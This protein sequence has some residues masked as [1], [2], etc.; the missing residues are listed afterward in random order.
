MEHFDKFIKKH[1]EKELEVPAGLSW[2]EMNIP[3]PLEKN[4]SRNF[5]WLLFLSGVVV[6]VIVCLLINNPHHET[7]RIIAAK[8]T[9]EKS[10]ATLD[11]EI[12]QTERLL[13]VAD[14]GENHMISPKLRFNYS[15]KKANSTLQKNN[16]A[17]AIAVPDKKMQGTRVNIISR[18]GSEEKESYSRKSMTDKN[19]V[20]AAT[21]PITFREQIITLGHIGAISLM[22]KQNA[23]QPTLSFPSLEESLGSEKP[24]RR[25]ALYFLGGYTYS[26]NSY[27][28]G[29]QARTLSEV[30]SAGHGRVFRLGLKF[31]LRNRFFLNSEVAAQK[32][33]T[34]FMYSE[35]LGSRY[36]TMYSQ[37]VER[38]RH[39]CH[40][41]S[42]ET[43]G[44][45]LGMGRDF[46]LGERFGSQVTFSF[47][48]DHQISS[49]GRTLNEDFSVHV[50]DNHHTTGGIVS[51]IRADLGV[52]YNINN[53]YRLLGRVG[54]Q[55]SITMKK[56]LKN[57]DLK[58]SPRVF[59]ISIGIAKSL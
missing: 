58:Y 45:R 22:L 51:G 15:E 50:M 55:Q 23:H 1:T 25:T 36:S 28:N 17:A 7:E 30:E 10:V 40:N 27:S 14:S 6:G 18:H 5:I 21:L 38:I 9:D 42:L 59:D 29:L 35:N 24:L 53:G 57:S 46:S 52:H 34:I 44:I 12:S 32:L 48:A 47:A 11:S 20:S 49:D 26:S 4:T 33:G 37:Y 41:N 3:L 39:I 19:K 31:S 56:F 2:E 13:M 43:I 16:T 54:W 8:K